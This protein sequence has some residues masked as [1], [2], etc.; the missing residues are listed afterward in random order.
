MTA[1]TGCSSPPTNNPDPDDIDQGIRTFDFRNT[2]WL[3]YSTLSGTPIL[4][5][6]KL[7]NGRFEGKIDSPSRQNETLKYEIFG[8]PAFA[9]VDDDGDEDAALALQSA[10]QGMQ[11]SWYMWVW[12]DGSAQQLHYPFYRHSRCDAAQTEVHPAESGFQVSTSLKSQ[13]DTCAAP[14]MKKLQYFVSARNGYPIRIHPAPSAPDRDCFSE[15]MQK[16]VIRNP[17]AA[18]VAPEE[19]APEIGEPEVYGRVEVS[20]THEEFLLARLTT[21]ERT[22]CGW[23]RRSAFGNQALEE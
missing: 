16:A 12:Q 5:N 4:L 14:P 10:D 7:K 6:L 22:V 8:S 20:V 11:L 1:V 19:A 2:L 15:D 9:D 17:I 21:D 18:K 3:D 13:K 23:V